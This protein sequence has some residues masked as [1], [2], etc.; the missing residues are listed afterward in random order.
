MARTPIIPLRPK[1]FTSKLT[2]PEMAALTWH[3][4][5]GCSRKDA[6]VTFARPDFAASKSKAAMEDAVKQFFASK[7][8]IAYL[9]AYSETLEQFLHPAPVKSEPVGTM[10]ERKN[11][12]KIKATEFAMSLAENIEQAEDAEYVL[13]LMDKVGLLDSDE[14][15][16]EL[17]RRYLPTSCGS[18]AY[19][20]FC[21]ENTEDM[22]Q[23][24]KYRRF[25]EENGIH[26]DKTDILDVLQHSGT[27]IEGDTQ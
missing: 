11:R 23:Y 20:M 6:F 26:Y 1:D 12:A 24:C 3:V 25:G 4:L 15:V 21:E 5:S 9:E 14:E 16:E 17:P 2:Q 19:R 10:E 8:A 27:E 7:E 13:K 22:C 18:C